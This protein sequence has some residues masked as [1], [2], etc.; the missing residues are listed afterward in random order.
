MNQFNIPSEAFRYI[1]FQRTQYLKSPHYGRLYRL[2]K[3]VV[4]FESI[5]Q[6]ESH[7]FKKHI[8]KSY[9]NDMQRELEN[10]KPHLP[11]QPS[12]ILDIGCGIAGIDALLFDHYGGQ[13]NIYLLD[14]TGMEEKVFYQFE[15]KG[16]VY[17][18]LDLAVEF[19]T[20][21]GVDPKQIKTQEATSDNEVMFGEQKFE[22]IIS[23]ISWGYHY[24]VSTYLQE[25]YECLEPGGRLIIDVRKGNNQTDEIRG[26]FGNATVID[27][28]RKA[29]RTLA[30]KSND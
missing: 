21:N 16:A 2:A 4:P 26:V 13:C 19:L 24:P 18:S 23:L 14:K 11:Q 12:A 20:K 17:N 1:L 9:F 30:I 3:K 7:L 15:S 10:L 25:A 5:V 22:L 6:I 29:Q 8:A 28:D 27:E